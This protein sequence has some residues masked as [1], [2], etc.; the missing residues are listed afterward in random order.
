[1]EKNIG[2][3][4]IILGIYLKINLIKQEHHLVHLNFL[5]KM[6]IVVIL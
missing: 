4:Y 1:M 3:Q 2:L 5:M 6:I